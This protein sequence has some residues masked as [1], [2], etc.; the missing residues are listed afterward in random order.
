MAR[1]DTPDL[2]RAATPRRVADIVV[3]V[4]SLDDVIR[5]KQVAARAKDLRALPGLL[6]LAAARRADQEAV[7]ANEPSARQQ[8][9]PTPEP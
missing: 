2:I 1:T 7:R 8:R 6:R 4:A 5:S 3:Q 9:P